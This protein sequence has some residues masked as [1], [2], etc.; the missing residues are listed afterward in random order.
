MTRP[1]TSIASSL[2]FCIRERA[3]GGWVNPCAPNRR[4]AH[5]FMVSYY[6]AD[7]ESKYTN[8]DTP[9]R[10]PVHAVQ[11]FQRQQKRLRALA[12]V[13]LRT[14]GLVKLL[15]QPQTRQTQVHLLR[16]RQRDAHVFDEVL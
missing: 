11:V 13:T 2:A 3:S 7:Y 12:T 6:R 8:L 16:F 9:H 14:D 4:D 5:E 15:R 10:L 1:S